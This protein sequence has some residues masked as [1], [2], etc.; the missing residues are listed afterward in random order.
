MA[1]RGYMPSPPRLTRSQLTESSSRIVTGLCGSGI[2]G[3]KS[4][5]RLTL[6]TLPPSLPL[7][8]QDLIPCIGGI[9]DEYESDEADESDGGSCKGV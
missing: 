8:E 1:G 2:I 4:A 6:S 7:G 9:I 5:M 3:S